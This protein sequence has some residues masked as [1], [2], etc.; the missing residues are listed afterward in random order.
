MDPLAL[1]RK[2]GLEAE[3][4]ALPLHGGDISRVWRVGRFVVK[5]AQDPPPGLFRAEARGL[6]AL[7]ERG[8]RVP[9]V[10]W[11]G[12]EGLVLAYLEPG[13]EDWE[14]LEIGRASCRERVCLYV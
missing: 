4:P 13:P 5:T 11:V 10:H 14:G 3:G 12:E 8:V 7:A 1:L 9:R 2:A 6:Q